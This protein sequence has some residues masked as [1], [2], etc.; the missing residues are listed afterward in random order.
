MSASLSSNL[1]SGLS[2]VSSSCCT[3]LCQLRQGVLGDCAASRLSYGLIFVDVV[4]AVTEFAETIDSIARQI[5]DIL[6]AAGNQ[7]PVPV[8][9]RV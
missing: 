3:T 1:Q 8:E 7:A 6:A 4:E 9:V 2:A 5:E